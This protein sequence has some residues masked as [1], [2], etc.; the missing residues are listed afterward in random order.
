MLV[1]SGPF[2]DRSKPI[3]VVNHILEREFSESLPP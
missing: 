1:S 3:T 2:Q